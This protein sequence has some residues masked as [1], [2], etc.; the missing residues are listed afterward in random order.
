MRLERGK[1]AVG[2]GHKGNLLMTSSCLHDFG[3]NVALPGMSLEKW[4]LTMFFW[5]KR[6]DEHLRGLMQ[7]L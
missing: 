4:I 1:L 3:I 7:R 6:R 5:C 2:P